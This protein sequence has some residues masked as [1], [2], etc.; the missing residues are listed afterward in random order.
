ME[1]YQT[2]NLGSET[3]RVIKQPLRQ[4][5]NIFRTSLGLH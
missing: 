2:F 1:N 5:S 3:L 4:E